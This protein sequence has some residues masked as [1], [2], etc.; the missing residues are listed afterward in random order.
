M[1]NGFILNGLVLHFVLPFGSET[2]G[3]KTKGGALRVMGYLPAGNRF[4]LKVCTEKNLAR[5][6]HKIMVKAS[7][8][9]RKD[10]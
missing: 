1:S 10:Y 9:K 7:M 8:M 5:Y 6:Q 2:S 4:L 3:S